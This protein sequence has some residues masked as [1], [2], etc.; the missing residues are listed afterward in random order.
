MAFAGTPVTIQQSYAGKVNFL[1]VAS[2]FRTSPDLFWPYAT[3]L[4]V[5]NSGCLVQA[6]G[7]PSSADLSLAV[8]DPAAPAVTGLPVGA[9]VVAAHLYWAGSYTPLAQS[10]TTTQATP[11]AN[12][13]F[14]G[15]PVSA[16]RI[17]TESYS[18][19]YYNWFG[20]YKDVTSIV[21]AKG[22]GI[23]TLNDLS[24]NTDATHCAS[25]AVLSAWSLVVI[26]NDPAPTAPTRVINLFDGFTYYRST[27][28]I[29]NPYNFVVP[30]A[31]INGKLAFVTWEGDVY[32]SGTFV[33]A[34][35][36]AIKHPL[37]VWNNLSDV[38][39]PLG[40]QFNSVS[41]DVNPASS[42]AYGVDS[43]VFDI[44]P[45]LVAGDTTV[46]TAYS[47]GSDLVI[48]AAEIFSTTNTPVANLSISKTHGADFN[49][50]QPDSYSINVTNNGPDI[51][52]VTETIT[53]TDTI[54][55]GLTYN[56]VTGTGWAC[57]FVTP[58]LTCTTSTALAVGATLPTI[59]VNVTPTIAAVP[60]VTN[61]ATVASTMFDHILTNNTSSDITVV[62]QPEVTV[63]K[64]AAGPSGPSDVM[65]YT[66][67]V[68]NTGPTLI[69][70][71]VNTD[72]LS[73]YTQFG[74]DCDG[75]GISVTFNDGAPV[76][77]L[78]MGT[79]I[80]SSTV[81]PVLTPFVPTP[82]GG[83]ITGCTNITGGFDAAIK[84]IQ[85]PMIGTMN[86]G[87]NYSLQY[88][89]QVK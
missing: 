37:G 56:S 3:A 19:G 61:T 79:P 82:T 29:L 85:I 60:S 41:N 36:F 45:Y 74:L 40:N 25:S 46:S 72:V 63:L 87:T 84:A 76:S 4:P 47:S 50:G 27:Q 78:S 16:D 17:F 1:T 67:Q 80:Y 10:A 44:S 58:T 8:V 77:G 69:T 53:V 12:V 42:T 65:T 7:V 51:S 52:A 31:P 21:A 66:V 38:N 64:S 59:T 89:V 2:S 55:A 23:Y 88:K 6:P 9:T 86:P 14:D 18:G 34:E 28:I 5:P 24:V 54:P 73:N 62:R 75:T 20:G 13:T 43:D 35:N 83:G 71:V 57:T 81:P 33:F 30:A 70:N 11:D 49:L 68:F 22:N 15:V 48:L 26:Y 39:N 32:N